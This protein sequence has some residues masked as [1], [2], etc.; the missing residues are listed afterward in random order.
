MRKTVILSIF[1]IPCKLIVPGIVTLVGT[2]FLS[3]MSYL[4][5][6]G[7]GGIAV[8]KSKYYANIN[9]AEMKMAVSN[10]IPILRNCA[11]PKRHTDSINNCDHLR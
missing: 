8:I 10:L 11:V 7:F 3:M 1:W 2:T 9:V 4:C 5:E 6:A